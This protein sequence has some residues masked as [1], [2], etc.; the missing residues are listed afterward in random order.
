MTTLTRLA[1]V[2][3]A[4]LT[5]CFGAG[6]ANAFVASPVLTGISTD[7]LATPVAMCGRTCRS[8][9]RYIPGPP[10]VCYERG[11][12]YCGSSRGGGGGG[13]VGV[14][15]PGPGGGVGIGVGPGG[16][17]VG[18]Q[19]NCRTITVQRDDGSVRRI[20]RCD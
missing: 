18:P 7:S 2:S 16:V 10:E 19:Q 3:A 15:V 17:V 9:G 6:G 8:G 4:L 20:R 11:L 14:V 5:L 12:E 1:F 13:G